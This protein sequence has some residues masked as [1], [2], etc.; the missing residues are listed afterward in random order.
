MVDVHPIQ[1]LQ[2]TLTKTHHKHPE[3]I[4]MS[5]MSTSFSAHKSPRNHHVFFS[6]W[7]PG[8]GGCVDDF[9]GTSGHGG[10]QHAGASHATRREFGEAAWRLNVGL[11]DKEPEPLSNLIEYFRYI[12]IYQ[13][14]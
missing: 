6:T 8:P 9:E 5:V 7:L 12:Y 11:V 10:T 2:K 3:V 14:W 4:V 1:F 13:P